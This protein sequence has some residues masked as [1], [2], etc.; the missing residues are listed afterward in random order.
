MRQD[1]ETCKYPLGVTSHKTHNCVLLCAR[2]VQACRYIIQ[3]CTNIVQARE[4]NVQ[5]CA[6]IV[7]AREHTVQACTNIVQAREH[8]VQTCTN[9]VQVREHNVQACARNQELLQTFRQ[10]S[11]VGLYKRNFLVPGSAFAFEWVG[12]GV[13]R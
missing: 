10:P 9:I 12:E 5:A 4:H 6:Q 7:Q 2:I 1:K 3:A 11:S 13:G 8:T